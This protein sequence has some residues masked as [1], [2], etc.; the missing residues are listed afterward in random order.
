MVNSNCDGIGA[1]VRIRMVSTYRERSGANDGGIGR[2]PMMNGARHRIAPLL[3]VEMRAHHTV[4][5]AIGAQGNSAGCRIAV[6]PIDGRGVIAYR[7]GTAWIG[8]HGE[9]LCS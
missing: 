2:G 8:E 1:F 6:A 3:V 9:R 5:L 7:L 4:G